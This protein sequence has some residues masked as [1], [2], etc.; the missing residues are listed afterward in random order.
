MAYL[1]AV[2][3]LP[4]VD[5]NQRDLSLETQGGILIVLILIA[6]QRKAQEIFAIYK[7]H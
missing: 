6:V 3:M 7:A 5:S 4:A 2:S 1:W